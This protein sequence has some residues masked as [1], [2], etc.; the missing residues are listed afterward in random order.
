MKPIRLA[1]L[2]LLVLPLAACGN[3]GPLIP[4][5]KP[6]TPPETPVQSMP[7]EAAST[8]PAESASTMP[9]AP[10]TTMPA[11]PPSAED[12]DGTPGKPR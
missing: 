1:S 11:T 3:K 6:Q 2:L 9:A 5:P 10:A 4:V 12:D 7:A 8:M